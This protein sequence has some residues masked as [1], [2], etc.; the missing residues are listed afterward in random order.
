LDTLT[1]AREIATESPAAYRTIRRI[2]PLPLQR[3]LQEELIHFQ[4]RVR[5][6]LTDIEDMDF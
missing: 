5:H 4:L 3:L 2:L 6:A 1:W